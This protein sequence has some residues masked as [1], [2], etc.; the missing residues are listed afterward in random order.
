[1]ND[2][3]KKQQAEACKRYYEK[4]KIRLINVSTE[5]NKQNKER[6]NATHKQ[7]Y[8]TN[9][10]AIRNTKILCCCGKMISK[11]SRAAHEKTIRHNKI[12]K[13]NNID[14]GN[15]IKAPDVLQ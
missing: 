9:H 12:M 14:A 3:Q 7:Y 2:T 4:N 10:D 6:Y 8:T 13:M 15:D 1:M 11:V 5:W